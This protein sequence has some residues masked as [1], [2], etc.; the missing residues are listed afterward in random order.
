MPRERQI[1]AIGSIV[2]LFFLFYLALWAPMQRDLNR[3]RVSVP[4]DRGKVAL[5]RAHSTQV[6]QLRARLPAAST[7]GNI[8]GVLEQSATARGLRQSINRMEPEG[9]NGARLIMDEVSFN[10]LLSWLA[11]LQGQGLRVENVAIQKRPSAGL[12]QARILLRSPGA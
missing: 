12:V 7:R 4:Q 6:Q 10:A 2:G 9:P 11:D 5:M 3:L 8:M 1:V